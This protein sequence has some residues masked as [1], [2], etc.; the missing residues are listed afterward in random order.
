LYKPELPGLGTYKSGKDRL[1]WILISN[2]LEFVS[3]E[4]PKVNLSDHQP[5]KA[6]L[7]LVDLSID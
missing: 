3:Y 2:D 4:V 1:D 6:T 7:K 5:V